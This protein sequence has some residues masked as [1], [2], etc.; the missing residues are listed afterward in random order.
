MDMNREKAAVVWDAPNHRFVV[1]TPPCEA[2]AEYPFALSVDNAVHLICAML[3]GWPGLTH[4]LVE[5]GK[6]TERGDLEFLAA[7]GIEAPK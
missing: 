4:A 7:A 6:R 1:T 5:E 2:W 3:A